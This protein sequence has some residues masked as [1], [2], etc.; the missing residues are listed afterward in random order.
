M[1]IDYLYKGQPLTLY[2]PLGTIEEKP[3]T[4][5]ILLQKGKKMG[6]ANMH[7]TAHL[8]IAQADT[9]PKFTKEMFS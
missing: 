2:I 5:V 7:K 4:T 6:T 3:T 1:I 9:R 8:Q